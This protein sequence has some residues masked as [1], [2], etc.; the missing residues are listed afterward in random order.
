MEFG[1][2]DKITIAQQVVFL[3]IWNLFSW[4]LQDHSSD[5]YKRYVLPSN[6]NLGIVY[7]LVFMAQSKILLNLDNINPRNFQGLCGIYFFGC[8]MHLFFC[9]FLP[10]RE[11]LNIC[12]IVIQMSFYSLF[13][14]QG[15]M[16]ATWR[17]IIQADWE[18][19]KQS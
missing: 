12:A 14:I 16:N 19:F 5:D 11:G 6:I 10:E 17:D 2:E 7:A 13:F 15:L 3:F 1:L 8:F 9:S 18:H 4:I